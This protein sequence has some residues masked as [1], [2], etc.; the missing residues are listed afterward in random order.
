MQGVSIFRKAGFLFLLLAGLR[1]EAEPGWVVQR[2]L[3]QGRDLI[4]VKML[5]ANTIVAVGGGGVVLRSTDSGN[6]W[7]VSRP[8]GSSTYLGALAFVDDRVGTVVGSGGM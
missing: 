6:S 7:T 8:F 4:S 3:P 1:S 2:P 5:D